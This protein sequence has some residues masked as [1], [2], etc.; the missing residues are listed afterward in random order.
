MHD[1]AAPWAE[2]SSL[3]ASSFYD[4][5]NED[6]MTFEEFESR[7]IA[8]GHAA[9]ADAISA[10]LERKDR[11]LRADLPDGCR[12]HDKRPKMLASEVGDSAS[13]TAASATRMGTP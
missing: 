8:Y 4:F 7:S 13:A 3:L 2:A 10:A 12:V 1:A 5:L 6:G 11:S 9:I